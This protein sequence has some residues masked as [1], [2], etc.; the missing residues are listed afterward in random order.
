MS[1]PEIATR[2]GIS[3][4]GVKYH[5]SETRKF[6]SRDKRDKK[7]RRRLKDR[8]KLLLERPLTISGALRPPRI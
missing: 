4:D 3:R 1:N 8:E 2:M 5:V 7:A 6:H